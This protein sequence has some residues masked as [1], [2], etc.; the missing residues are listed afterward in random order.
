MKKMPESCEFCKRAEEV[1]REAIERIREL[2][3]SGEVRE[4]DVQLRKEMGKWTRELLGHALS[5]R[6]SK[7][8]YGES[9]ECQCG[10]RAEFKQNRSHIIGTV[11]PGKTVETRT[12][13]YVCKSCH[14]GV[15]PLLEEMGTDGDGASVGL[16]EMI[17]LAG[18][19]EPYREAS[20]NLLRKFAGVEVSGTCVREK[21]LEEGQAVEKYLNEEKGMGCGLEKKGTIQVEIDGGMIHSDDR[22][23]EVKL[24]VIFSESDR[25]ETSEGRGKVMS[26][27]VVA[28]RGGC[29]EFAKSMESRLSNCELSY[30]KVVALGD[31]AKWI[32]NLVEEMFPNRVEILDYYHA[33]EHLWLCAN[34]VFG[35]G[36]EEAHEWIE[37]QEIRLLDDRVFEVIKILE[38][39]KIRLRARYKR[40]AVD[41][42]SG[43]LQA[44]LHRMR[45]KTYIQD[46]YPI[47]SG[48]VE[49]A[50]KHVVQSRM[51]RPGTRWQNHGADSMLALRSLYRSTGRWDV[52]WHDKNSPRLAA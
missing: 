52:Y 23:Q 7:A 13:Y 5:E 36:S 51:K 45:Y 21:S 37:K 17:V 40:K 3:G 20:E 2:A 18:T 15:T 42:L 11:L 31:G 12:A 16:Q 38:R 25:V 39:M 8:T 34:D 33:T 41:N 9:V 14:R 30:R 50:V 24:G 22:W 47:G 35:E 49:S 46:G 28:V 43:Y 48:A 32:W 4:I 6:G 27:D 1:L 29:D 10:G 26:R 19:I 44:N